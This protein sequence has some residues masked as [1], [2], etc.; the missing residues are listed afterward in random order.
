[1]FKPRLAYE[2]FHSI[3]PPLVSI[4]LPT[5]AARFERRLARQRPATEKQI[6]TLCPAPPRGLVDPRTHWALL[7]LLFGCRPK[8]KTAKRP[9]STSV[10]AAAGSESTPSRRLLRSSDPFMSE[11]SRKR[12]QKQTPRPREENG[13][14]RKAAGGQLAAFETATPGENPATSSPELTYLAGGPPTVGDSRMAERRTQHRVPP[15]PT[16]QTLPET[17][18]LWKKTSI[19]E[20][21][22]ESTRVRLRTPARK[23]RKTTMSS[24]TSGLQCWGPSSVTRQPSEFRSRSW[25]ATRQP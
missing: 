7:E 12:G 20:N 16:H 10:A 23:T 8:G 17:T 4:P 22:M 15:S 13:R 6:W 9:V 11:T 14:F 1:V 21:K 3:L 2:A 18:A 19:S 25:R 24:P 5:R